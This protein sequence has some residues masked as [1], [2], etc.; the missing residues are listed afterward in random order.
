M[1]PSHRSSTHPL[2][3]EDP[4]GSWSDALAKEPWRY[5]FFAAL[6][7]AECAHRSMPRL[8][9]S[10]SPK[11]EPIRMGQEPSVIFAPSTLA[12]FEPGAVPRLFVHFFGLLGANGP[13]PLHLTEFARDRIRREKD[14]TFSRFLDTFHHRMML[15]FYRAW[16][17]A[18]PTVQFDRPDQD[19][20]SLYVGSLIGIAEPSMR[21]A[22]AVPDRAKLFHSGLL[23]Q[24]ARSAEL[25]E[26]LIEGFFRVPARIEQFVGKWV[27]LPPESYCRLGESRDTGCLGTTLILGERFWDCHQK[28]RVVMGAMSYR[29]YCRLLSSERRRRLVDVVRNYLGFELEWDVQ[30]VLR[31]DEVPPCRLGESVQLGWTSWLSTRTPA[32]DPDDLILNPERLEQL[33]SSSRHAS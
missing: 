16:A 32:E 23:S 18:Q 8:G 2:S 14:H 3:D 30:L 17:A 19:R 6:R 20:F 22:D 12:R 29:D 15:L 31:K 1:A 24:H 5:G 26:R 21:H 4:T 25:L 10:R 27:E 7:R 13:L 9:F 33:H 28:F 11:Q